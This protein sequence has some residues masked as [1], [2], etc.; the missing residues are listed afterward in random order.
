MP[1]VIDAVMNLKTSYYKNVLLTIHRGW[2]KGKFSNA[3][4]L[5]LI[6]IIEGIDEGFL[7]GNKITYDRKLETK[8]KDV[9]E[10]YE[11]EIKLAL[12]FKPFY[13]S[14]REEYYHI[15][16]KN[17]IIPEHSWHTPSPKFIREYIEYAYLDD[18]LWELLQDASIRKEFKQILINHYLKQ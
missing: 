10:F 13:H 16:W 2:A 12:F 3:K 9:C 8:Y 14:Q 1:S 17:G 15:H 11:P 5:F 6:A 18:G 4:P 7:I